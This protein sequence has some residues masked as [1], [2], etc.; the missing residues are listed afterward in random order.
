MRVFTEAERATIN[1]LYKREFQDMTQEEIT[2][3]G[4]WMQQI[5]EDKREIELKDDAIMQALH[6]KAEMFHEQAKTAKLVFEEHCKNI[7]LE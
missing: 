1:D 7:E 3:Y 2:L 5:G 4:E 6:A